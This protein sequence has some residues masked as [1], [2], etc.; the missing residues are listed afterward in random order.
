MNGLLALTI[1]SFTPRD[2]VSMAGVKKREE[3]VKSLA[4]TVDSRLN[5]GIPAGVCLSNVS[6]PDCPVG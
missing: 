4:S 2:S 3:A 1:T 5:L 6:P